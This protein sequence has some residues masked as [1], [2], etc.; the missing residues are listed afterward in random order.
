M[1]KQVK[2]RIDLVSIKLIKEASV[3]YN[4]RTITSSTS[5]ADLVREFIEDA[6]REFFIV[7]C[8]DTKNQPTCINTVSVGSLSCSIVHPRESFKTAILSNAASVIFAHNHPSS[9]SS[10]LSGMLE[11]SQDDIETT[12]RLVEA[13]KILGIKVLDHIIIGHNEWISFKQKGLM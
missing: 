8:L 5:A 10:A 3:L 11:P 7:V 2:K 9:A 6:D 13:G 12:N 4:C 1:E